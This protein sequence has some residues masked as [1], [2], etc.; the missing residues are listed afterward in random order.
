MGYLGVVVQSLCMSPSPVIFGTRLCTYFSHSGTLANR[1]IEG[2]RER[3]EERRI[4]KGIRRRWSRGPGTRG[5]AR[6]GERG[7]GRGA[8]LR[9]ADVAAPRMELL[10]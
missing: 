4:G 2:H 7:R 9:T 10:M 1:V 5:A 8:C 6:G 3:N